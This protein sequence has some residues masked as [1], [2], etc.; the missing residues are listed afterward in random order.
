MGTSK[1]SERTRAKIIEAAGELFADFG[2]HGVT[3]RDIVN[4]AQTHLSALNYHFASKEAL[5]REVLRLACASPEWAKQDLTAYQKLPAKQALDELVKAWI[6]D[7]THGDSGGWKAKLVSRE[8]LEASRIFRE[9][10]TAD[11]MPDL[12]LVCEALG[13]ATGRSA[14]S[15]AVRAAVLGLHG[16]ITTLTLYRQLLDAVAQD[17]YAGVHAGDW[18]P[19]AL[20][21]SAIAMVEAAPQEPT[22]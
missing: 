7:Y 13:R 5:Y 14:Q 1:D 19:S 10:V 6:C 15:V 18:L 11:A 9:V 3:V 21:A 22:S 16:Q 20:T 8:C 12:L 17:L 4:K 2:Y